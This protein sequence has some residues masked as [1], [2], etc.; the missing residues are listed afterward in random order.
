MVGAETKEVG[1]TAEGA[2]WNPTPRGALDSSPAEVNVSIGVTSRLK[3]GRVGATGKGS[4]TGA[5]APKEAL[6]LVKPV[7]RRDVKRGEAEEE[8]A[9]TG[10]EGGKDGARKATW[11]SAAIGGIASRGGNARWG[12]GATGCDNEAEGGGGGGAAGDDRRMD[13]SGKKGGWDF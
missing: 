12:G 13:S 9:E 5:A 11:G 1:I 8:A 2:K 3:A 4:E 6:K 7:V 10:R